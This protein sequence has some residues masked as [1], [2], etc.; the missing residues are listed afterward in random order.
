MS[1]WAAR[2]VK[3]PFY[4]SNS[5]T[6]IVCE[7]VADSKALKLDFKNKEICKKHMRRYCNSIKNYG[8]CQLA[9]ML[10]GK[11]D[12]QTENQQ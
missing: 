12:I 7:G 4:Q 10:E 8:N 3:C 1:S 11:Y 5:P 9:R 6:Q 2:D